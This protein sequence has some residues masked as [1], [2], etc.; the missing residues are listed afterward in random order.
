MKKRTSVI[1]ALVL[2]VLV[3]AA[4]ILYFT[5]RPATA[6]G[7]KALTIVVDAHG[8]TETL[9]LETD[10]EYLGPALVNKGIAEGE[11][12]Q[13]GMFITTVQGITADEGAEEWWY[14]TQDGEMLMTGVDETPIE[15]GDTFE[16]TLT[17]GW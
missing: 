11:T 15:D 2:V 3:A 9:R 7:T 14:I 1:L 16:F 6:A 17:T 5:T 4:G 8:S 13:Y 10:E 12:G